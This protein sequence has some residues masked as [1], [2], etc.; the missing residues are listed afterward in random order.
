MATPKLI[1]PKLSEALADHHEQLPSLELIDP[2]AVDDAA[3]RAIRAA[4]RLLR[5]ELWLDGLEHRKAKGQLSP[6]GERAA[7]KALERAEE[8]ARELSAGML[9]AIAPFCRAEFFDEAV[10]YLCDVVKNVGNDV[11]ASALIRA[12]QEPFA[13]VLRERGMSEASLEL[14]ARAPK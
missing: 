10:P 5:F 14:A 11:D 4:D 6:A 13:D 9:D 7:L 12:A 1:D 2:V 8:D 3:T